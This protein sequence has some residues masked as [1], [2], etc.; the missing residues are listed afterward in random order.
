MKG[1]CNNHNHKYFEGNQVSKAAPFMGSPQAI[2][3]QVVIA[4]CTSLIL[5]QESSNFINWV[6]WTFTFI[7]QGETD[8]KMGSSI[9][10]MGWHGNNVCICMHAVAS[11]KMVKEKSLE[12]C[13]IK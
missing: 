7:N 3:Y 10:I 11:V 5:L 13:I 4:S 1:W 6:E 12:L 8:L 2:M 9:V